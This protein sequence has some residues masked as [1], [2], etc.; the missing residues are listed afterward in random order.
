MP[1]SNAGRMRMTATSSG[2][3]CREWSSEGGPSGTRDCPLGLS[4]AALPRV[5]TTEGC[6]HDPNNDEARGCRS[7]FDQDLVLGRT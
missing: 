2:G 7:F 1:A 6:S 4:R 5:T 3:Y